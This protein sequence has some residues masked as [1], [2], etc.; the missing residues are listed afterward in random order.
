M[1][2]HWA[3]YKK[4]REQWE[5]IVLAHVMGQRVM[6][7]PSLARAR[8]TL[9]RRSSVEPDADNLRFSWKPVLDALKRCGIILD[10]K[11]AVIGT[12]VCIWEKAK[13]KQ[14][15]I[16]VLVEEINEEGK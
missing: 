15:S 9:T 5:M 4:L 1:R 10:D 8:I 13:P 14:G 3:K 2:M 7:V 6:P 11:P 16:T 12:P